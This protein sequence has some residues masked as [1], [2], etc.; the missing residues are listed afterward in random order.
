MR[1]RIT[2]TILTVVVATLLITGLVTLVLTSISARSSTRDE[3]AEQAR[4]LAAPIAQSTFGRPGLGRNP[5]RGQELRGLLRALEF[6]DASIVTFTGTTLEGDF[7]ERIDADILDFD[8]LMETGTQSGWSGSTVYAVQRLDVPGGGLRLLILTREPDSALGPAGRWF[9]LAATGT[10]LVGIA[11]ATWLA[12]T[13]TR[14]LR[15]AQEA[16][17]R[18]A[19]GDLTTRLPEP[20]PS[21]RDEL[22]DLTRSINEMTG[23]LERSKGLEQQFLLS[24][25]HDLRTPLTSIRGYAE[26][27]TDG[28]IDDPVRAGEVIVSEAKRLERL[29]GDL[30]DLGRLEARQFRF[31]FAVRD[32]NEMVDE[33]VAG[34][35]AQAA[36]AGVA[37]TAGPHQSADPVEVDA[38]RLAQAVSNLVDNA[39][40][41]AT[42]TVTVSTEPGEL[43]GT[44]ATQIV[45]ADDGPGIAD[46]DKP[47]IF[48]RLYQTGQTPV[49]RESGTG[50]GLA[51]VR[52]L[53]AVM[54]G[55][56]AV[57]DR[58]G[59]GTRME[60]T[61]PVASPTAVVDDLVE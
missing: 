35:E 20:V 32:A 24:V 38:D 43:D 14:P 27:L 17:Q 6:D 5:D 15:Q 59:G 44:R 46:A 39:L 4:S 49:R 19:S 2:A 16:T 56:V 50:L 21:R 11:A 42:S 25:S 33:V 9:V 36:A 55:R 22:S 28:A 30:L 23:A 52:E 53:V 58:V 48:E 61:L 41:F 37:L 8:Q 47:F 12:R 54:G 3:L 7:P 60:I 51:I 18:I 57:A 29:V 40:K 1:R 13:L 34:L 10:L 45:V 31:E 26:G